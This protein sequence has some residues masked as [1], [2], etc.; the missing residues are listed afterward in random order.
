M[1]NLYRIKTSRK[2]SIRNFREF[3]RGYTDIFSNK[4]LNSEDF[5]Y[6]KLNSLIQDENIVILQGDKGSSMVIMDKSEYLQKVE[7]MLEEGISKVT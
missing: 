1:I 6:K 3:S 2:Y 4:V 5:P 7:D